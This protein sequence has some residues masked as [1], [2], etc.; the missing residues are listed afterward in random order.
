MDCFVLL[1]LATGCE[2]PGTAFGVAASLSR[3]VA[4]S[5]PG[6]N[7]QPMAGL[8]DVLPHAFQTPGRPAGS[9]RQPTTLAYHNCGGMSRTGARGGLGPIASR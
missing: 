4:F 2:N 6:F 7:A 1:L 3:V 8:S 5:L 9:N